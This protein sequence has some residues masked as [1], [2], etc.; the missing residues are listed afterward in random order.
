MKFNGSVGLDVIV[1]GYESDRLQLQTVKDLPNYLVNT[2]PHCKQV[3]MLLQDQNT[4]IPIKTVKKWEMDLNSPVE[5]Y[6]LQICMKAELI[7]NTKLKTFHILFL[8]RS[9][10]LNNVISKFADVSSKCSFC[11]EVDE[12]FLH[13]FWEC[14]K[15]QRVWIKI[16]E[17]CNEFICTKNDKMTKITCML[18][19]LENSLLVVIVIL[20]KWFVHLCRIFKKPLNL[21]AFM[22]KLKNFR[23]RDNKRAKYVNKEERYLKFWEMLTEDEVFV[24]DKESK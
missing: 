18:S 2:N 12:S 14:P 1:E 13:V 5:E 7:H 17:F 22:E 3:R 16:I 6:W 24:I 15:V 20:F 23:D 10:M 9:F 11:N 19:Y 21:A 8:N 4:E